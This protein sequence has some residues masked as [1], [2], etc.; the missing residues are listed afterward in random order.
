MEDV[1]NVKRRFGM[2]PDEHLK[3][4][5]DVYEFFKA[6]APEGLLSMDG[7]DTPTRATI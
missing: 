1:A 3:I 6:A 5:Q 4:D 2:N 7:S